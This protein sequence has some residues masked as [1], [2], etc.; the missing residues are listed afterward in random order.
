[1]P[2]DAGRRIVLLALQ[3][4][5]LMGAAGKLRLLA[6]LDSGAELA[7]LSRADLEAIAGR[8]LRAGRWDPE[9]LLSAAEADARL[10]ERMGAFY[11]Q[12]DEAGFPAALREIPGAPFGLYF[13]GERLPE[14]LPAV[15]VV[16]TRRPTGRGLLAAR[17]LSRELSLAGLPVVSGLALGVDA[18]AHRGALEGR[19][20]SPLAGPTCA[21]LPCGV[22][23][24]YPAAHR[25]LAAAILASG[26]LLVSE[27]AP[28]TEIRK[29]SFPERNRVISGLCRGILVVEAPSGSGALITA[30]FALEQGRDVFV[31]ASRLAGPRSAGLDG[32]ASDGA[33]AV[34]SARGV[35]A[36]WGIPAA[37]LDGLA[38]RDARGSFPGYYG[39][40]EGSFLAEA[41]RAEL[42]L[43]LA[44]LA[45]RPEEP[46]ARH[47]G[48]A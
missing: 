7:S 25:G 10:L 20:R 28:G 24:V 9:A 4:L 38:D 14:G 33:L 16:G 17:S 23:R 35:L 29:S 31:A 22:E 43:D 13:R 2:S 30:D 6:A 36:E 11:L 26:G 37:G 48:Q 45:A 42:G 21:V 40:G 32:L 47:Y 15:A 34:A 18:E 3:R 5:E 12:R 44:A 27:F 1:M 8:R 41:L 19:R 39:A 46:G